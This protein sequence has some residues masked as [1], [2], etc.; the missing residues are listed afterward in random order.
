LA[1]EHVTST[2]LGA[3]PDGG[4]G[5]LLFQ[6]LPVA[7]ADD[8]R[9]TF[10]H[11]PAAVAVVTANGPNGPV[12][13]TVTSLVSVSTD[14]PLVSFNISHTSSSWPTVS[15]TRHVGIHLLGVDQG[16]LAATFA[17]SGTDRFAPPTVWTPGPRRVPVLDGCR[18]WMVG[19]V[20]EKVTV[21]DHSIVVVRVLHLGR[22]PE[23]AEPLLYH[24][25]GFR[26]LGEHPPR[27]R[28]RFHGR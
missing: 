9:G 18:T 17:R 16:E 3:D 13:L 23:P 21:G 22:H 27:A 24:D 10:R 12:G 15:L 6:E 25:G 26:R 20:L 28:S 19:S 14:P 7:S 11:H 1:H 5:C 4:A 8:L 2:Q